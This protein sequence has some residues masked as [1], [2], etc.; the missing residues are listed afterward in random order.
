MQLKIK[1]RQLCPNY[2]PVGIFKDTYLIRELDKFE[3]QHLKK[4]GL[5]NNLDAIP[6]KLIQDFLS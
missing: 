4:L 3:I 1:K 2:C 6:E 5:L